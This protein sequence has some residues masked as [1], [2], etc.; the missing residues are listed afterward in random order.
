MGGMQIETVVSLPV[1]AHLLVCCDTPNCEADSSTN[2]H[3]VDSAHALDLRAADIE[4]FD[5]GL[6]KVGYVM[7]TPYPEKV[8]E[9]MIAT[10]LLKNLRNAE[11]AVWIEGAQSWD[12]DSRG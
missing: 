1:V 7:G 10:G 6:I 4:L 5:A 9:E 11:L 2:R 8:A 12:L 3:A